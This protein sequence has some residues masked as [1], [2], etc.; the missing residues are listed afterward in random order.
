M[1]RLFAFSLNEAHLLAHA[2][3]PYRHLMV[4]PDVE[5]PYGWGIGYH[6]NSEVLLRRRPNQIGRLDFYRKL[7]DVKAQTVIGHVRKH[8]VGR[9][10]PENTHPFRYRQWVFAH[11]GTIE[12]FETVKP[13]L[14]NSIPNFLRRNMRG[15]TDSEHL[16]FLFLAFLY[17]DGL[18]DASDLTAEATGHALKN[19]LHMVR[20]L[21][22]E[23]GGSPSG[24]N[25]AVTNGRIVVTSILDRPAYVAHIDGIEDCALC[26]KQEGWRG[27]EAPPKPHPHLKG[28]LTFCDPP[29]GSLEGL[30]RLKENTIFGVEQDYSTVS[31]DLGLLS[32]DN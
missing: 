8:T 5:S 21:V 18:I 17:D 26:R 20:R 6:Q 14:T 3:Y 19:T 29:S 7:H 1:S 10:A 4:I 15:D 22:N 13:W 31:I 11:H 12:R 28:V 25:V 16:F 27:D 32:T 23:A 9:T 30:Q 24:L 2:I